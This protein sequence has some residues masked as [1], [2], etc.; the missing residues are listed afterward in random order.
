MNPNFPFH[1]EFDLRAIQDQIRNAP[2]EEPTHDDTEYSYQK[3]H[4][5]KYVVEAP[6][7]N[8]DNVRGVVRDIWRIEVGIEPLFQQY[9]DAPAVPDARCATG[10]LFN[11]DTCGGV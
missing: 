2:M 6:E 8:A 10:V 11:F 1:S 4:G 5:L 7:S 3:S 9:G